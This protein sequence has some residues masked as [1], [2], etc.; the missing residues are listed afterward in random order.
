MPYLE[1]ETKTN[2]V[3]FLLFCCCILPSCIL[4]ILLV[5]V[6]SVFIS[7]CM[8][9][10][11]RTKGASS[12]YSAWEWVV[13][14]YGVYKETRL[15]AQKRARFCGWSSFRSVFLV[16]WWR[17]KSITRSAPQ[18]IQ[19]LYGRCSVCEQQLQFMCVCVCV[20]VCISIALDLLLF[21]FPSHT[22]RCCFSTN[23]MPQL[24]AT[25]YTIPS[26]E[27]HMGP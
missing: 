11:L 26:V 2:Q 18:E 21:A 12:G 13:W 20:C 16:L 4:R 9:F 17:R 25:K 23:S 19:L 24:A 5:C 7:S 3:L 8:L 10:L 6:A 15:K 1:V 22:S 27:V 14:L